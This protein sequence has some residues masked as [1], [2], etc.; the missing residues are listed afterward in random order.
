MICYCS[1]CYMC[2]HG[3]LCAG[4]HSAL[5]MCIMN[6][7]YAGLSLPGFLGC[8][9]NTRQPNSF[10]TCSLGFQHQISYLGEQSR[11]V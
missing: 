7:V 8:L 10:Q 1:D 3:E 4:F 6:A 5:N 9:K 11:Y 2:K